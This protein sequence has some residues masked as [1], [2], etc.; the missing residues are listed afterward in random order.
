MVRKTAGGQWNRREWE[1]ENGTEKADVQWNRREWESIH[2]RKI[3]Q[4][5]IEQILHKKSG[6]ISWKYHT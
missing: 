4:Q 5:Q 1:W 3:Q 2:A 6:E